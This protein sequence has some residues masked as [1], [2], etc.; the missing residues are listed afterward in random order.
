MPNKAGW[1]ACAC[2]AAVALLG[3]GLLAASPLLLLAG[4]HRSA[5]YAQR[6]GYLRRQDAQHLSYLSAQGAKRAAFAVGGG[7]ARTDRWAAYFDG[8]FALARLELGLEPRVSR[9][10]AGATC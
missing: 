8:L 9:G 10:E 4:G 1:R 6:L 2:C 5:S 3:G 7:G